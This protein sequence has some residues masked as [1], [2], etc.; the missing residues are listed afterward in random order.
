MLEYM[1]YYSA[2]KRNEI[3]PIA[4]TWMALDSVMLSEISQT[5]TNTVCISHVDSKKDNK[6]VNIIKKEDHR[7]K[8]TNQWLLVGRGKGEGQYRSRGVRDTNYYV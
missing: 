5:K 6:V 3:L 8:R 4:V 2:I 7:Y 1:E